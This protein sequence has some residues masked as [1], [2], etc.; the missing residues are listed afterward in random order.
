MESGSSKPSS[1]LRTRIKR[2]LEAD[3][4]LPPGEEAADSKSAATAFFS[5]ASPG[6]GREIWF[7]AYEAFALSVGIYLMRHGWPQSFVVKVLRRVRSKLEFAHST[8]LALDPKWLFDQEEIRRNARAGD[9]AFNN[10]DPFLLSIVSAQG[11]AGGDQDTPIACSV[12]RGAEGAWRFAHEHRG[13]G[14]VW[15]SLDV[16]GPAHEVAAAL[17]L[18]KPQHRGRS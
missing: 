14:G 8:T 2:L 12:D 7:S 10:Q 5:E 11:A 18:T 9:M 17:A 1:E 6:K 13:A 16:V 4:S 15:T 3:R